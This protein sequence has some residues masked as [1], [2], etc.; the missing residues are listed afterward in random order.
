MGRAAA[1]MD[2]YVLYVFGGI[3][4]EETSIFL[5]CGF[6][7]ILAILSNVVSFG[8]GHAAIEE[9]LC[10]RIVLSVNLMLRLFEVSCSFS[11]R[12]DGLN[13]EPSSETGVFTD[14]GLKVFKDPFVLFQIT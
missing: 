5:V 11:L 14:R 10:G 2:E 7:R 6:G 3:A 4:R 13:F 8:L 1:W 9:A 12:C